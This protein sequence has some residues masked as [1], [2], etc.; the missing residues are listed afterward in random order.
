MPMKINIC[1]LLVWLFGALS[2]M[3]L[4]LL[5]YFARELHTTR[6][7][8]RLTRTVVWRID[9][10][11]TH[12]LKSD[13]SQ[14]LQYLKM[15]YESPE[16]DTGFEKNLAAIITLERKVATRDVIAYLRGKTGKDFG[17]DPTKWI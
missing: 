1:K 8:I 9:A 14:A 10:E 12:V 15:F 6:A 16:P 17:D 11:R 5:V 4:V 2:I 7:D 3:L 13:V